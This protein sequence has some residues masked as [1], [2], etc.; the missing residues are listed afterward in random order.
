MKLSNRLYACAGLVRPGSTAADVGTDHGHLPIYLLSQGIC[1]RVI[2]S[3]L[4]PM[5]LQAAKDNAAQA[6][7]ENQI[8]FCLSD[9]LQNVPLEGIDTVICAGMGGD[10][11]QSILL[12]TPEIW[13]PGVQ[14]ILQPQAA[15]AELRGFLSD[16]G[17]RIQ[18]EIF[19][20]DGAFVYTVMEVFYGDA[21]PIPLEQRYIPQG[22]QDRQSPL[23]CAY[24]R[25]IRNGLEKTIRGLEQAT[26]EPNPQRLAYYRA[27][28]RAM[29]ELEEKH[30]DHS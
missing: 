14:F 6:G 24:M 19:A 11:I 10:T 27:S 20:Q 30:A 9:G 21:V 5:P 17:F 18:Q 3:D 13:R 23:Y 25:R 16:H 29:E 8:T 12:G 28:L 2:A 26:A 1:S 22:V 15:V 4:R 7:V